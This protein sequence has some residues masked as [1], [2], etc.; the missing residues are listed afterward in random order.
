MANKG[1]TKENIVEAL[2][3]IKSVCDDN[4]CQTCPLGNIDDTTGKI[5]CMIKHITPDVWIINNE[6]DVWRALK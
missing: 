4:E 1:I 3:V 5:L 6:T 2:K